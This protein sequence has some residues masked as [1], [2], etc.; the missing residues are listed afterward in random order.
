[1]PR[2]PRHVSRL[3]GTRQGSGISLSTPLFSAVYYRQPDNVISDLH[4]VPRDA[5]EQL[6]P[7]GHGMF[8]GPPGPG[9]GLGYLYSKIY[10]G[11]SLH[12]FLQKAL[13]KSDLFGW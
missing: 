6:R 1:M 8:P 12:D 13:I 9:R 5:D 11:M 7:E 4:S 3:S 2:R 10:R